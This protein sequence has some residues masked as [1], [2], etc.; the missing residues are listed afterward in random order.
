MVLAF[1]I[2]GVRRGKSQHVPPAW[3]VA[4]LG[5]AG[6]KPSGN[7]INCNK[8]AYLEPEHGGYRS[9]TDTDEN[10]SEC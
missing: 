9:I 10:A 2:V 8:M 3:P 6:S 5:F 7:C 4:Y 1:S